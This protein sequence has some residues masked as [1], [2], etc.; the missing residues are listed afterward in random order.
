VLQGEDLVGFGQEWVNEGDNCTFVFSV[1]LGLDSNRWETFPEDAFTY[2]SS[3]EER[4]TVSETVAFFEKLI[5]KLDNNYS[6]TKLEDNYGSVEVTEF[7]DFTVHV[8]R[9]HD[10]EGLSK[11]QENS[12]QFGAGLV[13][14]TVHFRAHVDFN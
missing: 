1:L 13:A 12:Q 6:K 10:S 7:V 9:E 3:N 14:I 2:F 4:D 8:A 11:D 5:D